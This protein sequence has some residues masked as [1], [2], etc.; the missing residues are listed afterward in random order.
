VLS[1]LAGDSS[2]G[3]ASA[4]ELA[5]TTIEALAAGDADA[6]R[7][8]CAATVHTRTPA[9]DTNSLAELVVESTLEAPSAFSGIDVAINSLILSDLNMSA[10][11]SLRATHTGT[12]QVG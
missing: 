2:V 5:G 12:L 9:L 4:L 7:A 10:E 11:W 8:A 1:V 3:A 6:L